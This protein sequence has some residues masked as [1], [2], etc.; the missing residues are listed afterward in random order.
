MKQIFF[1]IAIIAIIVGFSTV[2]AATGLIE[3]VITDY[4]SGEPIPYATIRVEGTG[5]SMVANQD[6]RYRI[7]LEKVSHHL[8]FSHVAHYSERI[9]VELI[10]SLLVLDV[11]LRP[12]VL[13]IKGMKV[14]QRAYDP[15]Q[16]IIVEAIDRKD[17]ILSRLQSYSFEAYTKLLV[18]D[19]DKSDSANIEIITETQTEYYWEY[20]DRQKEIII[21]RKQSANVAADENL[22][23]VG[24]LLNLNQNRVEVDQYSIVTPTARDALN[25]YNYYLLD[26]LYIDSVAVFRLEVEPKSPSNPLFYGVIDIVDSQF[27]VVGADLQFTKAV[28]LQFVDSLWTS[29]V[30]ARFDNDGWM[31]VEQRFGAV[32]DL[33]IPGFP[34]FELD[35]VAAMHNYRFDIEFPDDTFDEIVL[36]VAEEADEIDSTEWAASQLIPLTEDEIDGYKRIDSI[37]SAPKPIYKQALRLGL[38]AIFLTMTAYDY[39]HFNRVEGPYLGMAFNRRELFP[40]L[41]VEWKTGWAFQGEYWQHRYAFDYTLSRRQKLKI[42]AECRDFIARRPTIISSPDHN[43]TFFALLHGYDNLDYYHERGFSVGFGI[44]LMKHTRLSIDYSDFDQYSAPNNTT[45]SFFDNGEEHRLNPRITPGKLRSVSGEFTWD[46]RPLMKSKKREE[47]LF[48]LPYIIFT[49]GGEYASPEF[50]DNDFDF[51]RYYVS[52]LFRTRAFGMG[53][54]SLTGF[55]GASDR[56]LPPQRYFTVDFAREEM[57]VDRTFKTLDEV[58]FIGN[59]AAAFYFDHDFGTSLFRRS[60]IPLIKEIPFSINLHGG[61]FWTEF[62]NQEIILDDSLSLSARKPYSELGFCIGRLPLLNMKLFFTWQLSDYDT[63]DFSFDF[64]FGF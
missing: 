43:P 5:R 2:W 10:D 14:Y 44:G 50:I 47:P 57:V 7:R 38:G 42:G 34:V 18:R 33:P 25:H 53:V 60:G 22:V 24:G 11:K 59:R 49:A 56:K 36:E 27:A 8:K 15:A 48:V 23:A 1:A 13:T 32:V 3:G 54:S 19:M 31:P 6:G 55:A 16:R 46:S 62:K 61:V 9:N 20:P 64:G 52:F 21:A 39:F 58:N 26:T 63:K 4:D 17:D 37:E 45:F 29:Q 12:S 28:D 35:Y 40:R 51:R 41:D 30:F